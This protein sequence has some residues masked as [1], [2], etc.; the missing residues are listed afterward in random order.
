MQDLLCFFIRAL[1]F[2]KKNQVQLSV[3]ESQSQEQ[4]GGSGQDHSIAWSGGGGH[5]QKGEGEPSSVGLL[6]FQEPIYLPH[7]MESYPELQ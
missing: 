4:Y 6:V 3:A 7:L 2:T 5:I 1:K